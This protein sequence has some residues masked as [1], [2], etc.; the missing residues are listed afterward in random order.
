MRTWRNE[1][2]IVETSHKARSSMEFCSLK[3]R[4]RKGRK[5][6]R[7][8]YNTGYSYLVTHLGAK[9]AKQGLTLLSGRDVVLSLWYSDLENGSSVNSDN[10]DAT[11]SRF[12]SK[13]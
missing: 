10:F 12:L 2:Q 7:S 4:P 3:C 13:G 6:K 1:E 9:R 8:Y 11:D 5:K